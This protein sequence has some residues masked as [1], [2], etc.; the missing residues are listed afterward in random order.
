MTVAHD[1][2]KVSHH[3]DWEKLRDE[4]LMAIYSE[5]LGSHRQLKHRAPR[6]RHEGQRKENLSLSAIEGNLEKKAIQAI[7]EARGIGA[8][9][10]S[11]SAAQKESGDSPNPTSD[12]SAPRSPSSIAPAASRAPAAPI[13]TASGTSSIHAADGDEFP[14]TV[15]AS[16]EVHSVTGGKVT[17]AKPL[18]K[19]SNSQGNDAS[20]NGKPIPVYVPSKGNC[21]GVGNVAV[22]PIPCAPD[23][24][25]KLCNKYDDAGSFRLCF[26]ACKPSFC[27]IHGKRHC[28]D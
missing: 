5:D 16:T 19:A 25:N 3:V 26:N 23:N 20:F 13:G 22:N 7:E 18:V 8:P 21:P 1:L 11:S 17:D 12:Q 10:D 14:I 9:K 4:Y 24:L 2:Q 15:S 27:C 6:P 28:G